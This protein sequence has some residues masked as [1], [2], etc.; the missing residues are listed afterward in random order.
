MPLVP[1]REYVVLFVGD[2]VILIV[3][4]WLALSARY[5]SIPS[6]EL[7][8]QHLVPFSILFALSAA[9]FFQPLLTKEHRIEIFACFK[10]DKLVDSILFGETR[11]GSTLVLENSF[12]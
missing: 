9:V 7:F 10:I 4:L 12:L 3:S 11:D 6:Q 5:L 8:I 2:V 1:K